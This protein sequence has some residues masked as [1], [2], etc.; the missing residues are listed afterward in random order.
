MIGK[1]LFWLVFGLPYVLILLLLGILEG[2]LE[3]VKMGALIRQTR[4]WWEAIPGK[5]HDDR[6]RK[7]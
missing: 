7:P 6:F 5:V 2:F 4:I 3:V 1:L